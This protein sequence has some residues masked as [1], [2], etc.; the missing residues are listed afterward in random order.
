M[1]NHKFD[2]ISDIKEEELMHYG[3]PR[4]S[5][6]YPWGSGDTPYQ[7]SG[8][9][10]SRVEYLKKEGMTESQISKSMDISSTRL[11][12]LVALAGRERRADLYSKAKTLEEE[13]MSRPKIAEKLGLKGE[14]SVRSLLNQ[15]SKARMNIAVDLADNLRVLVD[16]KGMLDIGAG[17]PRQ[18]KVSREKM[19]QAVEILKMEGYVV[20]NNKVPQVTNKGNL[21]NLKVLC[22]PGT[23]YKEVYNFENIGTVND[24]TSYDGG[25]TFKK[26]FQYPASLDSDRIKVRYSEEGGDKKDGVIELRRG[27]DDISLGTSNY[28]QV[29]ILVDGTHYLKGMAVYSDNMPDG[30]DV[31]FNT[32]KSNKI[33]KMDTMKKIKD[34]PENPFGSTIKENGGQSTYID[35]NGVERL[36]VINKRSDE[37]D[38]GDWSRE[39]SA[40]F[41]SKQPQ[42]LIKRQIALSMKEKND[43]YN[44]IMSLTNP[45]VKRALLEAYADDCDATSVS[46]K[47]AGLPGARYKVILPV[48]SLKDTE[49]YA[50]HLDDGSEVALV[51]YPH[52]GTFEI[53]TLTVNNRNREGVKLMG[54]Q[55]VDAIGIN[56]NVANILS[57]ADFD[58][59]TVMVIPMND[60]I[61][62]KSQPPLED[63]KDF[64][65]VLNYGY[66]DTKIVNGEER[67]YRGG[68]EY[69][70]MDE[71]ATQIQMGTI[72]NLITDMTLIG[73]TNKELARAV[74][75][76][77]VIIDANKHKLDYKQSEKDN[78]I[79]ALHTKYQSQVGPTGRTHKGAATLISKSKGRQIVNERKLG[80]YVHK[81]TGN[82]LVLFDPENQIYLD[83]K[84]NTFH[85]KNEKKTQY[86]DPETGVKLYRYT[87]REYIKTS[88]KTASGKNKTVP[89]IVK[90]EKLFYKDE[91]GEYI[92]VTNEPIKKFKAT[93]NS[94]KMAEVDDAHKLSSGTPQEEAYADYANQ[95][96]GLANK[97]RKNTLTIIDNP[98]SLSAKKSYD[99]EVKSLVHKISISLLNAPKER[100]AQMIANSLVRAK[101]LSNPRMTSEELRK[102][103]QQALS[104]A[105][106]QAGAARREI[107]ITQKEWDAI[108]AG[109]ISTNRLKQIMAH[110]NMDILRQYAMPRATTTLSPN[111]IR[112]IKNMAASGYTTAEIARSLGIS[113]TTV[114]RTLKGE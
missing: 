33:S 34:D 114:T 41:L 112:R 23:E 93:M 18:L 69:S 87:G 40:Q 17:V 36:T 74:K 44:E 97:A 27:V 59:D 37:G 96:K 58:G 86:I 66:D 76:S 104:R 105:R 39:I 19:N 28:A 64:D 109:A 110:A 25:K 21:T 55:A 35:K 26:S 51:R 92:Q 48:T 102:V 9:F 15:D 88:Y 100:H 43:E 1:D 5:G 52:G 20:Y 68:R 7:R 32:N 14:S 10:L 77:M 60:R 38:W 95:L 106:V 81:D 2:D 16:K 75:H 22:K 13:G 78:G 11:R 94:T 73:A 50:P 91:N 42:K 29:R 53:P 80:K 6:R 99:T 101:K 107:E 30:I 67:Y 24:L 83:P 82:E 71:G 98:T 57:G 111:K 8:D 72:S 46:L 85:T 49:V 54:K 84:R 31:I 65:T 4:H 56:A 12:A 90:D 63:L 45:T 103:E 62:I 47:A 79:R 61:K 3:T 113:T 108:Q 70:I 89:V